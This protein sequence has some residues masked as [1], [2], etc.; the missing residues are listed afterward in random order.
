MARVPRLMHKSSFW[1]VKVSRRSARLNLVQNNNVE[2]FGRQGRRRE[3][4]G[5]VGGKG[6][7][8]E[9]REEG[10]SEGGGRKR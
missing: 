5:K 2:G 9:K 8:E 3:E 4:A 6:R 10:R 1:V 7:R